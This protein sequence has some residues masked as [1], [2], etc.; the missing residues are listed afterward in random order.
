MSSDGPYFSENLV[1]N[2]LTAVLN[3][4]LLVP[5]ALGWQVNSTMGFLPWW[6]LLPLSGACFMT[7]AMLVSCIL[8]ALDLSRF[9][10]IRK[11]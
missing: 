11:D 1:R 4:C 6:I 7:I 10:W 2:V 8:S 3:C 5:V 9:G